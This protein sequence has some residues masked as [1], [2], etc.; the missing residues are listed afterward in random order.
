M[1]ILCNKISPG[2]VSSMFKVRSQ[3][4]NP[5]V[6]RNSSSSVGQNDPNHNPK[7]LKGQKGRLVALFRDRLH[8]GHLCTIVKFNFAVGRPLEVL[9]QREV[10]IQ[11]RTQGGKAML[12]HRIVVIERMPIFHKFDY[13]KLLYK[14]RI[15]FQCRV[16]INIRSNHS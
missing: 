5:K 4:P 16:S 12:L 2:E 6:I 3:F 9:D 15:V 1:Q 13:T 7:V 11:N 14:Q 8:T 10:K